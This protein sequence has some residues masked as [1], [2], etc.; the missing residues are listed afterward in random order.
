MSEKNNFLAIAS[1]VNGLVS[2]SLLVLPIQSLNAGWLTTVVLSLMIGIIECYTSYLIILHGKEHISVYHSVMAHFGGSKTM[3]GLYNLAVVVSLVWTCV[4]EFSFL[5]EQIEGFIPEQTWV[6]VV[7][8]LGLVLACWAENYLHMSEKIM[9]MGIFTIF[10]LCA[11]IIWAIVT[12]HSGPKKLPIV[13]EN[14]FD[15]VTGFMMAYSCH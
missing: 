9:G 2:G 6:G 7:V 4:A 3:G 5:I 15:I 8:F 14:S 12:T 11:F 13:G 1:I 10:S